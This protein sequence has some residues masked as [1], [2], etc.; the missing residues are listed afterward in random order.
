VEPVGEVGAEVVAGGVLGFGGE[1]GLQGRDPGQHAGVFGAVTVQ[2]EE[3]VFGH[4]RL[5]PRE[6]GAQMGGEG[7]EG[8]G[9][10]ARRGGCGGGPEIQGVGVVAV[11]DRVAQGDVVERDHGAG[12]PCGEGLRGWGPKARMAARDGR[13]LDRG[14]DGVG[15]GVPPLFG[16]SLRFPLTLPS[17][18]GGEGSK[19]GEG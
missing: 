17:P 3:A 14:Q 15:E 12:R 19:V 10:R 18:R 2:G 8:V 5:F 16:S 1:G 13:A 7:G 11:H 6:M 4:Q 9:Q